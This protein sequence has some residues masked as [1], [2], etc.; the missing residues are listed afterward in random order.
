MLDTPEVLPPILERIGEVGE[1]KFRSLYASVALL[2]V[3]V[4]IALGLRLFGRPR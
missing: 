2:S 4:V 3:G 1:N